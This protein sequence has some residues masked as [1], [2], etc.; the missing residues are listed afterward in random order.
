MCARPSG[1]GTNGL[2]SGCH[3]CN[4]NVGSSEAGVAFLVP[5]VSRKN[6]GKDGSNEP[7]LSSQGF[8]VDTVPGGKGT[9]HRHQMRNS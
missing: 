9:N 3:V 1:T 5:L 4:V 2:C 8:C 7:E 6:A